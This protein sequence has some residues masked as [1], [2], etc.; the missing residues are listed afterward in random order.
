MYRNDFGKYFGI[1][2]VKVPLA[3]LKIVLNH[4]QKA[5]PRL[6]Y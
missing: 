4:A 6:C 3:K 2:S 5:I 1:P